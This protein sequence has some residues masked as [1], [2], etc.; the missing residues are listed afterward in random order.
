[1]SPLPDGKASPAAITTAVAIGAPIEYP[2]SQF[3]PLAFDPRGNILASG[4]NGGA[5][6]FR[7][8]ANPARPTSLGRKVT[9]NSSIVVL[10]F[11]PTGHT[12]A[13]CGDDGTIQLWNTTDPLHP[14]S[15]GETLST[16][17]AGE[18]NAVMKFS[19]D[20]TVLAIGNEFGTVRLWNVDDPAH[21]IIMGEPALGTSAFN[22]I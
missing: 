9:L 1:F 5:I 8:L 13:V 2:G 22:Q 12:L 15:I 3:L 10:A 17:D 7:N 6:Q 18:V 19:N 4:D 21:P 14:V 16:G 11:S 20:G